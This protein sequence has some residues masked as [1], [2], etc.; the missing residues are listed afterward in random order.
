MTS[1]VNIISKPLVDVVVPSAVRVDC[2]ADDLLHS[3]HQFL[4][5][6]AFQEARFEVLAG[7]AFEASHAGTVGHDF[8]ALHDFPLVLPDELEREEE[9]EL[10]VEE[11]VGVLSV[12]EFEVV[13]GELEG[14]LL[15]AE[16]ARRAAHDE[17]EVYVDDVALVVDQDVVVVPVLYLEQILHH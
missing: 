1:V 16:V 11:D 9:E 3:L 8:N 5:S 17:A 6:G 4:V 13:L 14:R 2:A 10:E 7:V 12:H 15:E